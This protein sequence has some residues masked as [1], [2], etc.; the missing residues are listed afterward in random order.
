MLA[1][2][3]PPSAPVVYSPQGPAAWPAPPRIDGGSARVFAPRAQS[4]GCSLLVACTLLF[5]GIGAAIGAYGLQNGGASVLG[6]GGGGGTSLFAALAEP[7]PVIESCFVDANGDAVADVVAMHLRNSKRFAEIVDGATGTSRWRGEEIVGDV[8]LFCVGHHVVLALGDFTTRIHDARAPETPLVVRGSDI[9]KKVRAGVGCL[10]LEGAD[11]SH[12]DVTIDGSGAT[13]CEPSGPVHGAYDD[14]PGVMS[15]TDNAVE[16]QDGD[17]VLRLHVR[18]RGTPILSLRTTE[19]GPDTALGMIKCTFSAA[20]AVNATTIFVQACA[21]GDD[22]SGFVVALRRADLTELWRKPLDG[23]S[24]NNVGFFS[25][26]GSA[27]IVQSFG[28]VYAYDGSD[29]RSLWSIR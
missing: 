1:T 5:G 10:D 26:N 13:S 15:L 6:G 2:G 24:T 29:G 20:L 4:R 19:G 18:E 3:A 11:A 16:L 25:W 23:A 9:T 22:D 7:T 14:A 28:A 17:A 8:E 12:L 27:L 21:P